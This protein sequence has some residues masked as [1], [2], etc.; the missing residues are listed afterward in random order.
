MG[1]RLIA[2]GFLVLGHYH[3]QPLVL[4]PEGAFKDSVLLLPCLNAFVCSFALFFAHAPLCGGLRGVLLS[5][6]VSIPYLLRQFGGSKVGASE[7][8]QGAPL[9][10]DLLGKNDSS[11]HCRQADPQ[12]KNRRIPGI[13]N[14]KREAGVFLP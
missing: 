2:T 11:L 4:S 12:Q 3:E 10:L 5:R 1:A 7:Q 13:D 6:N 8:T 14:V 9:F